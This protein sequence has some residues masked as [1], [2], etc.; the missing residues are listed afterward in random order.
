MADGDV[1]GRAE[2]LVDEL[3]DEGERVGGGDRDDLPPEVDREDERRLCASAGG[4]GP[5]VERRMRTDAKY[6]AT[7]ESSDARISQFQ[8][9]IVKPMFSSS[10]RIRTVNEMLT[11]WRKLFS[12]RSIVKSMI[13]VPCRMLTN[14]QTKKT[15]YERRRPHWVSS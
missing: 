7:D 10:I 12:K 15:K 13:T 14:I 5:N 6:I 4:A 9:R 1:L 11:M 2:Q 8:R 3:G